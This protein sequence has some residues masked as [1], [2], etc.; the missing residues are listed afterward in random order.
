MLTSRQVRLPIYSEF[1]EIG[2]SIKKSVDTIVSLMTPAEIIVKPASLS[3]PTKIIPRYA[4]EY[5]DLL[6]R[7][8]DIRNLRFLPIKTEECRQY[9]KSLDHELLTSRLLCQ[10]NGARFGYDLN[11]Y[12]YL[13]PQDV[14]QKLIWIIPPHSIRKSIDA[15]IYFQQRIAL[16]ILEIC[17]RE[18]IN[19]QE[20]ILFERPDSEQFMIKGTFPQIKH[21]HFW[22]H[23]KQTKE[24]G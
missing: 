15:Y 11:M 3:E 4:T 8:E 19:P 7:R 1:T 21:M 6:D 14:V 23:K 10:L 9:F 12:P 17:K 24:T 22:H 2:Y 20:I 5:Q 13:L 16:F 18:K